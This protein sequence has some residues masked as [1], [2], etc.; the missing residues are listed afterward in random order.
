MSETTRILMPRGSHMVWPGL[1]GLPA[2]AALSQ[3]LV[4]PKLE[5]QQRPERLTVVANARLVLAHSTR[6]IGGVEDAL[7]LQPPGLEQPPEHRGERSSQPA[8]DWNAKTLLGPSENRSGEP[9]RDGALE[10]PL[11]HL[12]SVLEM[13]GQLLH[14]VHEHGVKKRRAYLQAAGHARPVDLGQD[15]FG[16]IGLLV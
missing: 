16:Q 4:V 15:V 2:K 11:G 12:L 10:Q 5:H 9:T 7:P 1:P 6:H 8:S 13:R 14:G 3:P